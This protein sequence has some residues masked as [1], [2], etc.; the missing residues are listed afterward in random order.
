M[1]E[2]RKSSVKA[3]LFDLDLTLV[4]SSKAIIESVRHTLDAKG[5][6][7]RKEDV[8]DLVGK[9]PLEDQF[10]ALV[11]SLSDEEIWECV[12]LYREFY[13]DHH[14]EDTV[15]YTQVAETLRCLEKQGFK[16]GIVTGKYRKP[17]LDVLNHFHLDPLFEAVVS[18]YEVNGHKP[19][20]KIV[21][22]AARKLGVA[23]SECVLVGDSPADV[24][25]GKRAGALTIAISREKSSRQQLEEAE[26]DLIIENIEELPSAIQALLQ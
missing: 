3:V 8:T 20:P 6:S 9:A 11:P 15:I 16:L 4:D 23:A 5:Y 10:R 26:P 14:L 7:Y 22:E 2:N 25:S 13:L 17:V 21:F 18:S 12:D 24:K 19:S 1:Y